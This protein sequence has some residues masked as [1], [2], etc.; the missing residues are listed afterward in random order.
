MR[1]LFLGDVMGRAGRE[2]VGRHLPQLVADFGIDFTIVNGENATHGRGLSE[3]HFNELKQAG[4]D[5]LTLGDHAFDVPETLSY[6]AREPTLIRPLNLPEGTPGRGAMLIAAGDRQ[7]LVVNAQG[8]VFMDP[9]D[10]PFRAVEAAV[11]ECRLGERADAIVVDF[12]CE[13]TS[14]IAA[15]GRFMDGQVSAVV[16]THTHVPTADARVLKGRTGFISDVGM[17]GD[18]DSVI[19]VEATEPVNRFLTG[20]RSERLEPAGGEATVCA[21]VIETDDRTG[22]CVSIEPVL[23][24]G[25]LTQNGD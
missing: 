17:C 21:V 10:D 8:R 22:L 23:R 1:I 24:G 4:A 5:A 11:A 2:A 25:E 20:L 14:E 6:I 3:A 12:H 18:F 19:G 13:A 7:V 9:I 16:G 15:M